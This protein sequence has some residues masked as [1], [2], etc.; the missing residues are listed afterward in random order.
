VPIVFRI[1]LQP[2]DTGAANYP[3]AGDYITVNFSVYVTKN[4]SDTVVAPRQFISLP[5]KI[6]ATYDGILF[7][8]RP[9]DYLQNIVRSGRFDDLTIK[10]TVGRTDSI[11]NN[12][13]RITTTGKGV[14]GTGSPFIALDVHRMSDTVRIAKF[15]TVYSQSSIDFAG[16]HAE[17]QFASD[18]VPLPSNMFSVTSV[19]PVEPTLADIYRFTVNGQTTNANVIKENISNIKVVPNPYIVSSLYEPEFGEVRREPVRQ[20]QFTNLPSQCTIYIFTVDANLVKTI[21]HNSNS[22][23][24]TW[25][26]KAEG[27]REVS[28][29][30]YM[31]LVKSSGKDH[32]NR[33]AI[34]K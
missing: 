17:I 12:N 4:D 24:A 18:A 22:G 23:T 5:D 25:D 2:T 26:L 34:I 27:G 1:R 29:G 32:M 30:T 20:M 7:S 8:V 14:N 13:Y 10:F 11:K 9:P 6:Q 16:I 28:S 15:D 31:Y 33:F 3:K 19:I 21:H